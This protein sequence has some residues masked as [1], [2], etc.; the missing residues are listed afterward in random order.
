LQSRVLTDRSTIGLQLMAG[1]TRNCAEQ[2]I[3]D[4]MVR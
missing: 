3:T 2:E 1:W 4:V